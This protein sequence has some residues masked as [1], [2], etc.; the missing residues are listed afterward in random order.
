MESLDLNS[1][2]NDV[3]LLS[4]EKDDTVQSENTSSSASKL[5]NRIILLAVFW[6]YFLK[7]KSTPK[8]LHNAIFFE[9]N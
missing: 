2:T 5:K 9:V 6:K 8:K 7:L 4:D 3:I 1:L